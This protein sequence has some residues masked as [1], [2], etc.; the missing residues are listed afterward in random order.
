MA[1]QPFVGP[2][3]LFSS[4][5]IRNTVGRTPWKAESA[6]RKAATHIYTEQHKQNKRRHPCLEWDSN[7]L[8]Q[9]SSGRKQFMP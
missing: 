7:T 9:C 8:P 1:Q 2:W 3:P 4:F 5:G 6:R